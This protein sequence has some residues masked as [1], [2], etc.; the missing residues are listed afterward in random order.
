MFVPKENICIVSS[1]ASSH[2]TLPVNKSIHRV[3]EYWSFMVVKPFTDF[4]KVIRLNA[5]TWLV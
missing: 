1:L 3:T 2:P 5:I 4:E